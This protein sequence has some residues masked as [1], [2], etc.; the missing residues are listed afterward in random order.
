MTRD[1][2]QV[3]AVV[4]CDEVVAQEVQCLRRRAKHLENCLEQ[5]RRGVLALET[6]VTSILTQGQRIEI[7]ARVRDEQAMGMA[8][9]QQMTHV[10]TLLQRATQEMEERDNQ[11]R[12]TVDRL[13][14]VEQQANRMVEEAEHHMEKGC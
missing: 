11:R 8:H 9:N 14:S 2:L 1:V 4:E 12:A 7:E 10:T 3:D 6:E 5:G 13:A